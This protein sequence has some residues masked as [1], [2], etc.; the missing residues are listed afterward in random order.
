MLSGGGNPL[1]V[2]KFI[3]ARSPMILSRMML[4]NNLKAGLEYTYHHIT[5]AQGKWYAW[6]Y[7]K[8]SEIEIMG[9]ASSLANKAGE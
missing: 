9:N 2:P 1:R 3:A 6:Y 5:F 4:L 8:E 7:E